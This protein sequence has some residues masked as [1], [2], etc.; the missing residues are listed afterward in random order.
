MPLTFKARV[1][2]ELGA[3]LI[4]SDAI[5]LYELIKNAVDARS[6]TIEV[7]TVVTIQPSNLEEI[8]SFVDKSS[9]EWNSEDFR[10]TV[11]GYVESSA[12]ESNAKRFMGTIGRPAT[13]EAAMSHLDE[14]VFE[15]NYIKVVDRGTG[16]T[17]KELDDNYLTVGTPVRLLQR[18]SQN[19]E[20]R[21][22]QP[23][24]GEKGIGRLAAMRLGHYIEVVTGKVGKTRCSKLILDWRPALSD[25]KLDATDLEFPITPSK[26]KKSSAQGTTILIRSLQSDWS[27]SKL[28]ELSRTDLCKL[29]D[30]FDDE[31]ANLFLKVYYQEQ[32]YTEVIKPFPS[33]LLEH[34][35]GS[36]SIMYDTKGEGPKLTVS[37]SYRLFSKDKSVT[38]EN[39]DL[40]SIAAAPHKDR[41]RSRS[42][43]EDQ[44]SVPPGS[45]RKVDVD[46]SCRALEELGPFSAKLYWFNRG[47]LMREES[48]KWKRTLSPFIEDWGG[49]LL[50][51][52]DGYRVYPYGSPADDW[53]DLDRKAFGSSGYKLNRGQ[54]IGYLRISSDQNPRLQDQT[55]REGFRDCPEK[56]VLKQL[57]QKSIYD[58]KRWTTEAE[59]KQKKL[60]NED[61]S[62]SDGEETLASIDKRISSSQQTVTRS[63][64]GLQTR[65][66]E[67]SK[68]V[69]EILRHLGDVE[70]AWARAKQ[71]VRVHQDE[72]ED[73]IQHAGVGMMVEVIAH[74]LTN[75][76]A[77]AI[78]SIGTG[79]KV[80]QGYVENL[81]AQ[82][83]TLNKRFRVI[84]D[85]SK[86]GR[87]R[88]T[89]Q[90]I[91]H[92]L[93][94]TK[95]VYM[96][97][98]ER[99]GIEYCARTVGRVK[100]FRAKVQKGAFVQIVD[101]LI[102]NSVY[103]L[104]WGEVEDAPRIEVVF[105]PKKRTIDI[106]DSGP[107]ISAG[108][109]EMVFQRGYTTKVS[110]GHGRGMGLFIAR[111]FAEENDI[112]IHLLPPRGEVH[113]G[114]RLTFGKV[115]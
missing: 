25:P 103:W 13:P 101:N 64:R 1:L 3:E 97:K 88:K 69:E 53:L 79:K 6:N 75:L 84:D 91:I 110:H 29:A 17:A 67:E 100:G 58:F 74:E 4:S 113:R 104:C 23:L 30:P 45:T 37:G 44:T 89:I 95:E 51:Y 40:I 81:K 76:T 24:L 114:F 9:L 20:Q 65:A 5:A 35:D 59:R 93:D 90:D 102:R 115:V 15:N 52:R 46:S 14:A 39:H 49:G 105:N 85:L 66:P 111:K 61:N 36:C 107:G 108:I 48:D 70:A 77:N 92:L 57:V 18:R 55:N 41:K 78:T 82:L 2:L 60:K 38:Y 54:I 86:P 43:R 32:Q 47:R 16:M 73:Y 34:R 12:P 98:M 42:K 112:Q 33:D 10:K 22:S 96:G 62:D 83:V 31:Y 7:R 8:R 99:H 63:L 19:K 68:L 109:G 87:Q 80:S 94:I 56:Q 26:I 11:E 21:S 71:A 72:V 28:E 27:L 50:V 106:M